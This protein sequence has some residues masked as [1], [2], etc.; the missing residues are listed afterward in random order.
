MSLRARSLIAALLVL[1]ACA[2][3]ASSPAPSTS[4]PSPSPTAESTGTPDATPTDSDAPPSGA[5]EFVCNQAFDGEGNIDI[6]HLADVS[7]DT[8][9][10][11]DRIVFEF[12]EDGTPAYRIEPAAPPFVQDPSG[13]PMTV[14]GSDFLLIALHGGTKVADDGSL[15][16]TGPTEFEPDFP[17]LVHLIERG[18][19]EAVSSWYIGMADSPEG[20][21]RAFELSDPSRIVIDVEH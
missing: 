15:A 5:E 14:N 19:F 4:E 1:A 21:F 2:P 12:I 13:Q 11:F 17:Q 18:D 7:V 8:Q 10:G 9:P 6:A 16:Y 3:S 20:C